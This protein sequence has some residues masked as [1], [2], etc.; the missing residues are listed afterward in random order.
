MTNFPGVLK[1][2]LAQIFGRI[3]VVLLTVLTTIMLTR[4]LGVSGY[5]NYIFIISLVMFFV[6]IADWGS[7][8]IFVRESVKLEEKQKVKFFGH[9]FTFRF[10]IALL[11]TL[12]INLLITLFPVWPDLIVPLR[13]SSLLIVLISAKISSHIVFQ[14]RLKFEFMAIIDVLISLFFLIALTLSFLKFLK[15]DLNTTMVLL[16][17]A[18]ILGT[19][20]AIYLSHRL[21]PF[22]LNLDS[23]SIKKILMEI[24]PTGALLLIFSIY[25]RVDII[26]LQLLKGA[27]PVGIYGL[28]YKVHDNLI[29][30]AAY[31]SSSLFPI[32]A[33][34]DANKSNSNLKNIYQKCFDLLFT[35]GFLILIFVLIFAP[36]I[37]SIIGGNNFSAS[38]LSLRILVFATFFAYLN[39]LNGYT[40]IALGKQ[41]I[42]LSVAAAALFGNV[43]LNLLLI[44]HY[45]YLASAFVTVLTEA[46]VY[47]L[48]SIYLAKKYTLLPKLTI[49]KTLKEI[50]KTRGQIF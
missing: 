20:V 25:N 28:S 46:F 40:L 12:V 3:G 32:L 42:S 44:P 48:T 10:L 43:V 30:G 14:S 9:A 1:N 29:L 15:L 34:L 19:A 37:I 11:A 22:R 17:L 2:T 4:N 49:V 39:H 26:I 21:S 35:A 23:S 36:L 16:V 50:I 18:N 8:M 31:L 5:G 38:I 45:S 33:L 6:S 27:D 13:I 7:S 24:L 47:L 41:R